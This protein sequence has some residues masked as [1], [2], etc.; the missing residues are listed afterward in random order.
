LAARSAGWEG[1]GGGV[2]SEPAEH[3]RFRDYMHALSHVSDAEERSL[4]CAVLA[5]PDRVMA[6]SVIIAHLD[7]RAAALGDGD[8]FTS[9]SVQLAGILHARVLPER[10]LREWSLVK[11]IACGRSWNVADL[12]EASDWVQRHLA[13]HTGSRP[14]LTLLAAQG[15]TRRIRNTAHAR[16]EQRTA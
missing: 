1:Y 9:W 5:D 16:L 10:R 13:E 6:D 2:G 14:A 4:I 11:D 3:G 15:R 8:A 7:R 12:V